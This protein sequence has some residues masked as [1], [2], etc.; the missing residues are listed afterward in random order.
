M[1]EIILGL[2]HLS[3]GAILDRARLLQQP[4]LISANALSRW[5]R[6][7][8][9][10]QWRGWKTAQLD[11]ASGLPSV[12]L[13]S[14]G[15]V[16]AARYG[17]IPWSVDQYMAL[18]AAYPFR[19]FASLDYCVEPEIARDR[20]E[21]L[22]RISRTIRAN[23][24]CR[25]RAMDLGIIDRFMPVIQGRT[26]E[27]YERCVDALAWSLVPGTIIGVGSMCRRDIHGPEGLMAVIEHLDTIL[28]AGIR[29]HAFGVKGA[30]LP[31]LTAFSARVASIDS[32]AY[33]IAARRDAYRRGVPKSDIM[34]ADHLERWLRAQQARLTEKGRTTFA[35]RRPILQA[36]PTNPW[37][38]AIAQARREIRSLIET[39]D[40]EHD[41][42]TQAWIEPWAADL[43]T[44][45]LSHRSHSA[46]ALR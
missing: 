17:G 4:V 11:N 46:G 9:W 27:D 44:Q 22:D 43:M 33:G 28:P 25:A 5:T 35:P 45:A 34:V 21:I 23:R 7:A 39:G 12:D 36:T 37:D 1:I 24:D 30:A 3:A 16:C 14:G 19:R 32:Q 2:P 31:F 18:A 15:F 29:L 40:L 10:A 13:D 6:K 26:P 42:L 38:A 41:A 20:E 8:G